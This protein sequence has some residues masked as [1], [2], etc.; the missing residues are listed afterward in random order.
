VL[1][2]ISTSADLAD[3]I[4]TFSRRQGLMIHRLQA[5]DDLESALA[6][7]R[8]AALAWDLFGAT[9][10]DWIIV[11]RLRQRQSWS[12]LPFIVFGHGQV[13]ESV[14]S[15]GLTSFVAKPAGAQTLIDTINAARPAQSAGPILIV[16]DDP[17]VRELH[18]D[19]VAQA[20]PEYPIR[21]A[22]DGP[23]ALALMAEETPS[24][25]L[26]DL[27]MPEMEGTDVL[28]QMRAD[29]RQRQVPVIILSSN[30][31]TLDDIRRLEQHAHVTLQSKGILSEEETIAL[32]QR[33]LF[34]ADTQ[35]TQTSALVKR[36]VA[37]LHQNFARQISRWELAQEVGASEDYLSRVF[38]RE[39]GLSPWEYLN[40][41]RI[42]R[43]KE[44]LHRTTDSISS[45]AQQ[46][47]FHDQR[48]FSRV[49]RSLTGVGPKEFRE[50]PEP[51]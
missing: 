51:L 34:D 26:L 31:L 38:N 37:Y 47:G 50:R 21:T 8:P 30:L 46:V 28:D 20:L 41:Y 9:P 36:A 15:V 27:V 17:K 13:D 18:R 33:V 42:Y 3:E 24:L 48:Y 11:R 32:L 49:F 12:Q 4:V 39:L 23:A 2:V 10:G 25:V 19:V 45:I 7:V 14:L 35:P 29:P 40:R 44:L 6:S 16:D 1:L 22:G 5:A 43:A